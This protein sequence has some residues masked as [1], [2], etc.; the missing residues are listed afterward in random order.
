METK[1]LKLIKCPNCGADHD[2]HLPKCPYCGF[3]NPEGAEEQYFSGLEKTR[4]DLDRVD[5]L[6]A[7]NL[8]AE[9]KDS[10]KTVGRKLVVIGAVLVLLGLLGLLVNKLASGRNGSYE[11]TEKEIRWQREV[12]PQLDA[13]YEA[14]DYDT[15][16]ARLLEYGGQNHRV[17]DWKHYGFISWYDRY[18]EVQADV[19]ELTAAGT[20]S[21]PFAQILVYDTFGF[22]FRDY[23]G[24]L[25]GLTGEDIA[26]LDGYREEVVKI[27]YERMHFTDA[28]MD[29][30]KK[31]AY[32]DYG[33]L[34]ADGCKEIAKKYRGQFR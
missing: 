8:K 30:L 11:L 5:D 6:A 2:I 4:T 18:T 29:E 9:V 15:A 12:F 10:A 21:E 32:N 26:V 17:W 31:T 25:D 28:Q 22:Y 33:I 7:E 19:R 24:T 16:A 20:C 14:G 23:A 34:D 13:L 27:I 3:M 1:E